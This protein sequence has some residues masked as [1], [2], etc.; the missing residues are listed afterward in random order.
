M[1]ISRHLSHTGEPRESRPELCPAKHQEQL[2]DSY[3]EIDRNPFKQP[4]KESCSTAIDAG[5]RQQRVSLDTS[6]CLSELSFIRSVVLIPSIAFAIVSGSKRLKSGD[7]P[8]VYVASF[9]NAHPRQWL[10]GATSESTSTG[11]L[12]STQAP[13]SCTTLHHLAPLS[14]QSNIDLAC[15]YSTKR[16]VPHY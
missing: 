1:P 10:A 2:I 15:M 7:P 11:K 14:A 6:T 4:S 5:G 3:L 8:V 13:S 16:L 12:H 9:H